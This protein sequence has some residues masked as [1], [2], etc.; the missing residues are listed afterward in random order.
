MTVEGIKGL[1]DEMH[2]SLNIGWMILH[3]GLGN[4][5]IISQLVLYGTALTALPAL[6]LA[7]ATILQCFHQRD[8]LEM[9]LYS[10]L[11]V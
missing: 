11:G 4:K 1:L 3:C 2:L 6:A 7:L 9:F 8:R 5:R 10:W